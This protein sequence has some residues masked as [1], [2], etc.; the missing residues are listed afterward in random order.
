MPAS[1]GCGIQLQHTPSL[2]LFFSAHAH[3]SLASYNLLGGAAWPAWST[4]LQWKA[5]VNSGQQI[6][7]VGRSKGPGLRYPKYFFRGTLSCKFPNP[8]WPEKTSLSSLQ[9]LLTSSTCFSLHH[10]KKI[11]LTSIPSSKLPTT[12]SQRNMH[13]WLVAHFHIYRPLC[14]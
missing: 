10:I 4:S 9:N 14:S 13:T 11:S 8:C 2:T 3:S 5:E 7:G 6:S 12:N 1:D